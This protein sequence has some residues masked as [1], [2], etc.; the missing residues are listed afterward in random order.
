MG[1][2]LAAR[3]GTLA[4]VLTGASLLIFLV[5]RA[6]PG[7]PAVAMMTQNATPEMI[8]EMRRQFGL[9]LPLYQQYLSWI[10]GA[11]VGDLGRSF[12]YSMDVSALI[13][14]RFPVTLHLSMAALTIALAIAVPAGVLAASHQGRFVDHLCRVLAM[15][16]VSMPVFWQG[17]LMI[18][19]FAVILGWLPPGGYVAPSGGL[20][21]SMA[22]IILPA[23]ALG[24]AYAATIT[25]MLRSS[26]LDVLGREYIAVARAHGVPER[27]VI[28]NDALRNALIPTLTA[29]GFSF[30]YLLAGAVLTEVIFNI[31]GMG[32]LLYESILARDY[33]LV[34]GLVL[35]NVVVFV[36]IT[37]ALDALYALLDP[38]IR[39]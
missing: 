3:A 13:R 2:F 24:T 31:P 5:L 6:L 38:R 36:L 10:G 37:F 23:T 11:L 30:G 27:V 8:E 33:P 15:I 22:S 1:R 32:R 35:L 14:E 25:R 28:W 39:R 20:L 19:L 21:A 4:L 12:T 16:G 7:D 26:M 29:V 9:H 34:Q 18:L 17:L